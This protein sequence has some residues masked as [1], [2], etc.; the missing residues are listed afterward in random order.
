MLSDGSETAYLPVYKDGTQELVGAKRM[1]AMPPNS[2]MSLWLPGA[3]DSIVTLGNTGRTMQMAHRTD[4]GTQ[5]LAE[6]GSFACSFGQRQ[7][8]SSY[9]HPGSDSDSYSDRCSHPGSDS[10][11]TPTVAPTPEVTATPTPFLPRHPRRCPRQRLLPRRHRPRCL[12]RLP[13]QRRYPTAAPTATP[14]DP[15]AGWPDEIEASALAGYGF[16]V[17]S[18]EKVEYVYTGWQEIDGV[19]YYYDPVTHEPVT[20][21]QVIQG[22]VYTFGA[23]GALNRTSRG[24]DVSKFRV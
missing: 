5:L 14:S 18:T 2:N 6:G 17:T 4:D 10:D 24:I 22:D 16:D 12:R 23:D 21:N 13:Q 11:S 15:T 8:N 7:R 9:P 20:G 19:T 3:A 1:K